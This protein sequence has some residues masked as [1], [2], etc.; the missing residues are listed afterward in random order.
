MTEEIVILAI[1]ALALY[2][3]SKAAFAQN[4][5]RILMSL[6]GIF[7]LRSAL[8]ILAIRLSCYHKQMSA[9]LITDYGV[10]LLDGV[11][12]GLFLA[13]WITGGWT[14]IRSSLKKSPAP[15]DHP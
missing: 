13:F 7:A 4:H 9:V 15:H 1:S 10:R 14:T 5:K 6:F 3:L 11:A 12:I 2:S 8:A